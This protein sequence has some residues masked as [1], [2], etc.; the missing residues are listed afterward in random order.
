MEIIICA[1]LKISNLE[2]LSHSKMWELGCEW[3]VKDS[4]SCA[5]WKPCA[6]GCLTGVY[7][8]S[9]QRL[10]SSRN[11]T[12]PVACCGTLGSSHGWWA[13]LPTPSWKRENFKRHW[14][15][16]SFSRSHLCWRQ[17]LKASVS[18]K[19]WKL[20]GQDN[21]VQQRKE[22]HLQVH[23]WHT[24]PPKMELQRGGGLQLFFLSPTFN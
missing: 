12:G 14:N 13:T 4:L 11:L 6:S 5:E 7:F 19:P 22:A 20:D 21:K 2:G 9:F 16:S 10:T 3:D 18:S 8:A 1:F 17:N 15:V 24:K 23:H